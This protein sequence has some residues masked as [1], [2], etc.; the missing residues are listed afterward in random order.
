MI[1]ER[2]WFNV[3]TIA[4]LFIYTVALAGEGNLT[5]PTRVDAA[6]TLQVSNEVSIND[7]DY[8]SLI[9]VYVGGASDCCRNKSPIAS[10]YEHVGGKIRLWPIYDFIEGQTYVVKHRAKHGGAAFQLTEF[11]I[12]SKQSAA[13]A[14]VNAIYPSGETLPENTLRFY[15]FFS[16]PM[17][18]HVAN[19]YIKLIDSAGHVDDAAF[20]KFKQELWSADRTR[21]TILFDPG[22]IKRGVATNIRLGPALSE[23]YKYTLKIDKDWPTASGKLLHKN[24]EKHFIVV[25]PIRTRVNPTLWQINAPHKNTKDSLSIT[26][27]RAMD[28]ALVKRMVSLQ[29]ANG[30][31]IKGVIKSLKQEKVWE[32]SPEHPWKDNYIYLKVQANVED[33]SGNNMRDSLDHKVNDKTQAKRPY[34]KRVILQ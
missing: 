10:R 27:D 12:R 11:K 4:A 13:L 16:E 22:R 18:P 32:F 28:C 34:I 24:F 19:D 3:L 30:K 29:N 6:I 5:L 17:Q 26:F 7:G 1:I 33:V 25:P 21:L 14:E 31:Q 20:M 9:A 23:G 15:I 2:L 8:S